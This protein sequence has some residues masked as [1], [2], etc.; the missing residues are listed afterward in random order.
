ML[1][2]K[3]ATICYLVVITGYQRNIEFLNSV[4]QNVVLGPAAVASVGRLLEM[5]N[6]KATQDLLEENFHF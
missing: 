1:I 3:E 5:K 2:K 4:A 6:I